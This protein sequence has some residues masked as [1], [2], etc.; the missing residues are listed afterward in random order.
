MDSIIEFRVL[1]PLEVVRDGVVL[2]LGAGKLRVVLAAL[3]L[4]A[5]RPVSID[6][7]VDKLWDGAAPGDA[8]GTVQKYV[9]RIRR[10]L[11]GGAEDSAV[12][13]EPDG[14]RITIPTCRLDLHRFSTLCAQAARAAAADDD[15]AESALLT[16]A[17]SLWRD[18]PPL[19][20][21]PSPPL[22]RDEVAGLVE[23]Y[24]Q[25]LDRRIELDLA[26]GRHAEVLGELAALVRR[27]PERERF[28]AH[29]MRAL[30]RAGRQGEA[31]AAYREVASLLA[32]ELGIDPGADL[33]AAHRE[34]LGA[35]APAAPVA[36]PVARPPAVRPPRQLP[37]ADSGF[38]GRE[39]ELA[40]IVD[41]LGET[42]PRSGAPV[43][44]TGMA[45]V[46]KT[47][48]AVRAAHGVADRFPDGALFADLR[49]H[50][51]AAPTA[52]PDVLARFVRTLGLPADALPTDEDELV[53]AYRSLLADRR[54]LV[55]LDGAASA[56]QVRPLLPGSGCGVLVTSRA[57]LAGLA[58]SPGSHRIVLDV[59]S[60][61]D[62][63]ALLA[64]VLGA[65][66]VAA[67]PAAADELVRLCG[68]SALALR[69][70]AAQ[71]VLHPQRGIAEHVERLSSGD[72]LTALRLDGDAA[73]DVVAALDLSCR[74][75]D[76][77]HR[78][79][80]RLLG[81]LPGVTEEGFTAAAAAAATGMGRAAV[82]AGLEALAAVSL[83][84][85]R[86]CARYRMHVLVR[87]YAARRAETE[88]T[89]EAR[90][91]AR[92][93]ADGPVIVG[94]PLPRFARISNS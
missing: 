13:T 88:E 59:L 84:D 38:A 64:G 17:L 7:L 19:S 63:R 85:R 66:R 8:R 54:M 23:R 51:P 35:P 41:A 80:L 43:V 52:V 14:Y 33:R 72:L 47:A 53:A 87:R 3:L 78:R 11:G 12:R 5:N 42:G 94:H 56:E 26:L 67:E 16:D 2:R 34:V 15:V 4:Q 46:G 18:V 89:P 77:E 68:G 92:P 37:M 29:R 49:G 79:L 65:P 71:L 36:A 25:A 83:L 57:D 6:D 81:P 28:W 9:M 58:V 60:G 91:R 39:T 75:L 21:V 22:Q 31:L 61:P 27:H 76:P 55:V 93:A 69:V 50:S 73:T 40:A 20:D 44:I 62:G 24:L 45:G 30:H 1:G 10:L 74:A 90:D 32:E 70:A 86:P 48:L 82:A